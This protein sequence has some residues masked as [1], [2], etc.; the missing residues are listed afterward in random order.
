MSSESNQCSS[1]VKKIEMSGHPPPPPAY[2]AHQQPTVITHQPGKM[3]I[4]RLNFIFQLLIST[5]TQLHSAN[6]S[7][8]DPPNYW[9]WSNAD[10]YKLPQ[11]QCFNND[12]GWLRNIGKNSLVCIGNVS[13]SIVD[14]YSLP[15][16]LWMWWMLQKNS[17][18]MSA[19]QHDDWIVLKEMTQFFF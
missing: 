7:N 11:L 10:L 14:V 12:N 18:Q 1:V 8:S 13:A 16:S 9:R 17:S 4:R 2:Y 6:A 3:E 15:L 19:M 5:L